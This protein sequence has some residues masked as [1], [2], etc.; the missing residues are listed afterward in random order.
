MPLPT[1][2]IYR[3]WKYVNKNL[4]VHPICGPCW[5]WTGMTHGGY[6]YLKRCGRAHRVSWKIH[7][8]NIP[9]G[10]LVCHKCDNPL[11][12]NPE[13]LFLGTN[14]D[15]SADMISKGRAASGDRH[16][17]H[18][19]PERWPR[20]DSHWT[21]IQPEKIARG[22][23]SGS[24]LHPEKVACGERQ[25]NSRL[26]EQEVLEIRRLYKTGEFTHKSLGLMFGTSHYNIKRILSGRGW[27]HLL[28]SELQ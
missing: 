26:K 12:V 4:F 24:R 3:F 23:Y 8:G 1:K 9:D 20:G 25:G 15:N 16:G 17:S 14:A 5:I 22:D 13:H 7:F 6:G 10:M 18:T 27:K 21:R 2:I 28:R 19:H 11:C